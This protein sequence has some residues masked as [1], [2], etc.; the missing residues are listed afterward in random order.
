MSNK[1]DKR[2]NCEYCGKDLDAKYRSKRFCDA[3]CR[4][5]WNRENKKPLTTVA[6]I[7]EVAKRMG[8][9]AVSVNTQSET[10]DISGINER[11]AKIEELLLAPQKYLAYNKR[12]MLE[13]ELNQLKF[14]LQ[15]P[16][17]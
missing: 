1:L 4:I 10:K 5:Y 2:T 12:T 8:K 11:I 7:K 13:A 16:T 9:E 3:K 17:N 6:V 14:K 15:S